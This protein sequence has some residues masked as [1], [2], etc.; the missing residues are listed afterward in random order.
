MNEQLSLLIQLQEIDGRIRAHQEERRRIPEQLA[1]IERRVEATKA[2]IEA[3]RQELEEA[4]KAKRGRDGDLEDGGKKVEKLKGRTTEIKTNKEYQALQKEIE[5]AEQENKAVED[6]I[7]KLMER[8]DAATA[9][10]GAAEKQAAGEASE[11][12]EERRRLEEGHARAEKEL[13]AEEQS[14]KDLTSRIEEEA[15]AEYERLVGPKGGKVV[16][17][18]RDE[19]CAGCYM[20]IPPR[21]FVTVKKNEGI[22][23]CPHCHRILYYKEMIVPNP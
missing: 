10:I 22:H 8:I 23:S 5:A 15:L 13:G 2:G 1:A 9:A 3:A 21:V 12:D 4:Q 7:L 17:E 16:V 14:R 20:S 18:A 19:S 11:I 6:D